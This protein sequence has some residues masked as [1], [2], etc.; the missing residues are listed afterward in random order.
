MVGWAVLAGRGHYAEEGWD[1]HESRPKRRSRRRRAEGFGWCGR[2]RL[3][4]VL[5]ISF[6]VI[7]A[8][9]P[10]SGCGCWVGPA[11]STT[12]CKT[13][14]SRPTEGYAKIR[15]PGAAKGWL[16]AIA[17]RV[18]IRRL[19]RRRLAAALG[20]DRPDPLETSPYAANQEQVVLLQQ[21]YRAL[22]HLPAKAR[23]VWVLRVIEGEKL[24]DI[25]TITGMG[26]SSVKRQLNTATEGLEGVLSE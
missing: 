19:R 3:R 12:S 8:W 13:S 23:V 24:E 21:I 4:S 2:R 16:R 25:A 14:S 7:T 11:T 9:S 26:L 20:L 17:V 1:L 10:R 15:E 22:E 6:D 18:A 5:M